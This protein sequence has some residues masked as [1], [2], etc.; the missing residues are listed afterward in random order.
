[1]HILPFL[2][3]I[4]VSPSLAYAQ[5]IDPDVLYFEMSRDLDSLLEVLV[6]ELCYRETLL[7][8]PVFIFR[9][10]RQKVRIAPP[11]VTQSDIRPLL[12]LFLPNDVQPVGSTC[13]DIH[14]AFGHVRFHLFVVAVGMLRLASF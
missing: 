5:G 10:E 12:L 7:H 14:K 2:S 9:G 13:V 8:E 4:F 6:P 1:M 3:E 11:A